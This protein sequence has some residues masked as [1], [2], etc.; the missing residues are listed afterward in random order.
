MSFGSNKLGG[1]TTSGSKT[2]EAKSKYHALC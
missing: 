1:K 2:K